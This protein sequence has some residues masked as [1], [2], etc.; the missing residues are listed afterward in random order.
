M[1]KLFSLRSIRNALFVA[2]LA[3]SSLL[4]GSRVMAQA[5]AAPAAQEP[6]AGVSAEVQAV[7]DRYFAALGGREK[8][9]AVKSI[10]SKGK[11]EI[12]EAGIEGEFSTT[13]K[14]PN[15]MK[16][17]F[18]LPQVGQQK[19]GFDG[20]T[21]WEVSE[22]MG[23]SIKE[24]AEADQMKASAELFTLF[25]WKQSFDKVEHSGR[26]EFNG[27]ECDVLV[28]T[29]EG[30]EP[31]RFFFS[32]KSGLQTGMK[33]TMETQVGKLEIVSTVEDYREVDGIQFAFKSTSKLPNGISQ[34]MTFEEHKVDGELPGGAFDL[35]KEIAELKD[36]KKGDDK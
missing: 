19:S 32:V 9:A 13:R 24:G 16:M 7:L 27:E 12:P 6:A 28:A 1:K 35:P 34:V 5:D 22:M 18:E 31:F 4:P 21:V 33:A 17:E 11:I 29:K 26:E 25:D 30:L 23:P 36:K 10:Q 8:L 3:A 20:E 15:L 14:A 2:G